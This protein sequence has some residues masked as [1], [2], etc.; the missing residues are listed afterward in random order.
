MW[1]EAP[2]LVLAAI[3]EWALLA[4]LCRWWADRRGLS[5]R[6]RTLAFVLAAYPGLAGCIVGWAGFVL[7][8]PALV[9]MPVAGLSLLLGGRGCEWLPAP[10]YWYRRGG[11][12][13]ATT[14]TELF[15]LVGW[16]ALAGFLLFWLRR[17]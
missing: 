17:R 9:G 16:A 15:L 7:P 2:I 13:A 5:D 3:V 10:L 4:L 14:V 1:L 8:L 11:V 6:Q 12:F